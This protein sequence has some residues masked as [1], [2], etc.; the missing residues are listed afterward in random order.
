MV[1]GLWNMLFKCDVVDQPDDAIVLRIFSA[2]S[3]RMMDHDREYS[4]LKYLHQR[5]IC[6]PLYCKYE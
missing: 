5:G 4:I 2:M 3:T 1:G 6:M